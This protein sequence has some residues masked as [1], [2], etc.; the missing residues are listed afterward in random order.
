[1]L[2]VPGSAHWLVT[3]T[4]SWPKPSHP[5]QSSVPVVVTPHACPTPGAT[6]VYVW[7]PEIGPDA[8]LLVASGDDPSPSSPHALKPQ[9]ST[10]PSVVTAQPSDVYEVVASAAWVYVAVPTWFS[11]VGSASVPSQSAP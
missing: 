5:Q 11:A 10:W 9:H 2:G 8:R 7:D 1:M 3:G 6:W 4:P